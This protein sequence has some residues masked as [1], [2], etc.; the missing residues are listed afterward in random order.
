MIEIEA[1][2][3]LK[4]LPQDPRKFFMKNHKKIKIL[5]S[6]IQNQ[7]IFSHDFAESFTL[8]SKYSISKNYSSVEEMTSTKKIVSDSF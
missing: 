5:T 8:R 7:N 1:E 3:A 4:I 6:Y 2:T